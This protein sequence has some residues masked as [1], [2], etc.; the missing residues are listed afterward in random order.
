VVEVV[1]RSPH[2]VVL[3]DVMP[4]TAVVWNKP[5]AANDVPCRV[6]RHSSSPTVVNLAAGEVRNGID[7]DFR[8]TAVV[9]ASWARIKELY[10]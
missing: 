8:V 2:A 6:G 7:L 4:P 10:R 1:I 5:R 9:P 3:V